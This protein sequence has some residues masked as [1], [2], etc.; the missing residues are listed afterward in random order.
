LYLF[1]FEKLFIA[2]YL[3][4]KYKGKQQAFLA[5]FAASIAESKIILNARPKT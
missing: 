2:A 5:D 3:N 1:H 4:W